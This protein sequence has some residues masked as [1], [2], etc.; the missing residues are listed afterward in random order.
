MN[1]ESKKAPNDRW[2]WE[3]LRGPVV[4]LGLTGV[5]GA[6]ALWVGISDNVPGVALL[7]LA[8]TSLVLAFAHRLRR[9]KSF[10]ILLVASLLG[11]FVAG[12]LHNLL[13][14]LGQMAGEIAVVTPVLEALHV[15]FFLAALLLCPAGVLVGGAGSLIAWRRA[16]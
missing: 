8:S 12:L 6:A 7:Y 14:G 13:Y 16:R 1:Q 3:N 9:V 11:F 2:R 15:A 4:F 10:V 5:A